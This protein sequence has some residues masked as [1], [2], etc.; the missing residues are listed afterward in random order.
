MDN[1]NKINDNKKDLVKIFITENVAE[2]YEKPKLYDLQQEFE[3]AKKNKQTFL[4]LMVFG[5][6]AIIIL[7]TIFFNIYIENKRKLTSFKIPEFQEINLKDLLDTAKRLQE[8]LNRAKEE[9]N[10]LIKEKDLEIQ[11]IKEK[12]SNDIQ[13]TLVK[14]ISKEQKNREVRSLKNTEKKL[15]KQINDK[16]DPLIEQKK[17]EIAEIQ[18]ELDK[19][20]TRLNQQVKEA[21]KQLQRYKELSELEIKKREEYYQKKIKKL[22]KDYESQINELKLYYKEYIDLLETK[23]NPVFKSKKLKN[24]LSQKVEVPGKYGKI[25]KLKMLQNENIINSDDINTI[26]NNYSD[27]LIL[28]E[29]L[30]KIPYKNSVPYAFE[31]IEQ[32]VNFL[33]Y[34]YNKVLYNA[35][36]IIR[37]KNEKI[38]NYEKNIKE[39]NQAVEALK[40]SLNHYL[41]RI[42]EDGIIIKKIDKNSYYIFI[43]DTIEISRNQKAYILKGNS[44]IA[45]GVIKKI[46]NY[47]ILDVKKFIKKDKIIDIVPFDLVTLSYR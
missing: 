1:E 47:Y 35:D 28:T 40:D 29:R 8:K 16:Y 21:Q 39:L 32:K 15:I 13:L 38:S 31:K 25:D 42:N 45:Y 23:Y 20:D 19:Y 6:I 9:L 33:N 4:W 14:D 44:I 37:F 43:K 27:I 36:E 7:V 5:F 10:A 41:T 12:I 17:Q 24:I 22:T 26:K 3:K 18:K 46:E 2:K 30:K 34:K 11:K